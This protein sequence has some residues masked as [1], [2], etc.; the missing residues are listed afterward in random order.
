[1]AFLLDEW[2]SPSG[3]N[4]LTTACLGLVSCV[5]HVCIVYA[6]TIAPAV[7]V[8]PMLYTLIIWGALF[9]YIFWGETIST[10]LIFGTP[11]IVGSGIYIVRREKKERIKHTPETELMS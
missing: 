9:G 2:Q 7:V 4:I 5:G 3:Y 10:M 6:Y 11:L 8:A 1:M